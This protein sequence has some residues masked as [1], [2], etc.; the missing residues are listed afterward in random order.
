MTPTNPQGLG[1]LTEEEIEALGDDD[2]CVCGCHNVVTLAACVRRLVRRIDE[3]RDKASLAAYENIVLCARQKQREGK[4]AQSV[5]AFAAKE[6]EF[7][8]AALS[9]REVA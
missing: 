8:R 6:S 7:Y 1:Y 4:D 5:G 9:S 3:E 2:G